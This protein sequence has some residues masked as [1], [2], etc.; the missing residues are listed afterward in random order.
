MI[1]KDFSLIKWTGANSFRTSHYPY[2]EQLMDEA[3]SQG[4]V[5]IDECPAVALQSF[6]DQLLEL[7]RTVLRELI[8]R[9]KNRPSVFLWSLANEPKSADPKSLDYFQKVSSYARSLDRSQRPLTGAISAEF[10]NC[11]MA[12]SLDLLM[13][14][15]YYA[16][17]SDAGYPQVIRDKL[18]H[19]L[20]SWFEQHN[21][22]VMVSEYGAD[23]ISGMHTVREEEASL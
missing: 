12:P 4:I 18:I 1:M 15:R 13:I 6:N 22:P 2:S 10:N 9:D 23:S 21:K 3:D 16:W 14:N 8:D 11:H 5:V 7:H 17:Y 20:Q 19:N